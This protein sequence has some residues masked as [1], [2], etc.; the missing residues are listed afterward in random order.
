MPKM[1]KNVKNISFC[2]KQRLFS[3][4]K[5]VG[6]F[7][8]S[9]THSGLYIALYQLCMKKNTKKILKIAYFEKSKNFTVIVSKMSTRA[10]KQPV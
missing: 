2:L 9:F 8:F 5:V 4:K 3:N 6:Y 10:N 1:V 7:S